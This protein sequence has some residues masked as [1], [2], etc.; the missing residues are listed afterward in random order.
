MTETEPRTNI[1]FREVDRNYYIAFIS[2]LIVLLLTIILT[3]TLKGVN[4]SWLDVVF[5]PLIIYFIFQQILSGFGFITGY[6]PIAQKIIN[7]LQRT[8]KKKSYSEK[9]I[10]KFE[11]QLD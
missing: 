3:A 4:T 8:A 2:G 1:S 6:I 11:K 10:N 7:W 5:Y 9:D